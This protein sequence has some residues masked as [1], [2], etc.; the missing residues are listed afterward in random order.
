[1]DIFRRETEQEFAEERVEHDAK[2]KE[3]GR[4]LRI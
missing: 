2:I 3:R 1:V 4:N